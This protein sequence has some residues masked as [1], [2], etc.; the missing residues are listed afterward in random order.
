MATRRPRQPSVALRAPRSCSQTSDDDEASGN[1]TTYTFLFAFLP[2]FSP[3][4]KMFSMR[5]SPGLLWPPTFFFF[6]GFF[7]GFFGGSGCLTVSARIP[8]SRRLCLA[9]ALGA[10][11]GF[12]AFAP[13]LPHRH[14]ASFLPA[15]VVP[16]FA[17]A[18]PALE[19]SALLILTIV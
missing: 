7:L 1:D 6:A 17:S 18:L 13:F 3:G 8:A 9:P 11:L 4:T 2:G 14:C 10:A 19:H 5:L 12:A 16:F 15:A